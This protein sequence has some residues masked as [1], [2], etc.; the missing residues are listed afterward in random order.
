MICKGNTHQNGVKLARYMMT[1]KGDERAEI[2]ELR[3]FASGAIEEAFRS[4]HVMAEGTKCRQPFFHVQ[5]RNQDLEELTREQWLRVVNRIESR[6]GLTD[7]PRAICFHIDQITGQEHMHVAW[8]RIDMDTMRAVPLP[9]FKE[10]LKSVARE[11]EIELGLARVKNERDGAVRA[12]GRNEFEEARRLGVD[13]QAVR[14]GIRDCF[15]HSDNGRSF[16]AA[17]AERGWVLAEGDRR[18]FVVI[19]HEGGIHAL[20]KRILGLTAAQTRDR[21]AD[22]DGNQLPGVDQARSFIR[23]H[24]GGR[25]K[26]KPEPMRDPHRDEMAWQDRLAKAAIEKEKIERQFVEPKPENEKTGAR[27]KKG[28]KEG[29]VW[30]E[31]ASSATDKFKDAGLEMAGSTGPKTPLKGIEKQLWDTY[32]S[33][34]EA[35]EFAAALD[36]RG[37]AF[38]RV[39]PDEASKSHREAQFANAVGRMAPVY[40]EGEIVVVRSPGAEYL[41]HGE[42][43]AL[44]RVQKLD[45]THA[46][47]YLGILGLDRSKLK[48]IEPTKAILEAS[49]KDRAAYWQEIRLANAQRRRDDAPAMGKAIR[50]APVLGAAERVSGKALKTLDLVAN[51]I[52]SLVAPILTPEQK[53]EAAQTA[54]ERAAETAEKIDLS[55]YRDQREQARQRQEQ[56]QDT[57]RQRQR[58]AERER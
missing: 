56:Q 32:R 7:Q 8:S 28:E 22:L 16:E 1:G 36:S 45:Q 20:G 12:P 57:T 6:L 4:V 31:T 34:P 53:R 17:L 2:F 21:L 5:V 3:G 48:G 18:A 26:A 13:I 46:E 33:G 35:Q 10:R 9:F 58:E 11:L 14:Q 49:A 15:E 55:Q 44:P 23:E 24:Q 47:K 19:D 27:E 41:R 38:A 54:R 42:W 40:Q 51:A 52:E 50:I 43:A 39:T 29:R 37:I 25:E 30:Q